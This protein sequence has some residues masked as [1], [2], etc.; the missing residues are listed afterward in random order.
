MSVAIELVSR[1]YVYQFIHY[2]MARN[3]QGTKHLLF[4][5]ILYKPRYFYPRN[6]LFLW[7]RFVIPGDRSFAQGVSATDRNST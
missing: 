1:S 4:L 5:W 7:K 6:Y 3:F 2:R